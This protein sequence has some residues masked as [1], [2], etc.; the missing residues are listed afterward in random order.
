A[1][2]RPRSMRAAER[3]RTDHDRS[4][5]DR[6]GRRPPVPLGWPRPVTPR[7]P[8]ARMYL[9]GRLLRPNAL[10]RRLAAWLEARP[11]L[12]ALFT[13][14]EARVKGRAFGCH[15]CGQCALPV[16]GYACP[17]GC[18]KQLRNGPCGGVSPTGGCEVYPQLRCVWVVAFERA[19]E[20]GRS[21]DLD[22]LH[23]PIDH[24][25]FGES[26]WLNYWQGRDDELWTGD[27][28]L[29]VTAASGGAGAWR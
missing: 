28:V 10:Y 20:Q 15:M 4:G 9:L 2:V 12:R 23:R 19:E 7:P 1:R 5:H 29:S 26:S 21:G 14:A 24:R 8:A 22:L 3:G 27:R 18:P 6:A 17:M 13:G 25:R 11:P 16:T